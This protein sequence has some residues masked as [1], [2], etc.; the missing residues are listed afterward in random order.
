MV[1]M[2]GESSTDIY[3]F[4]CIKQIAG[5]K[6]LSSTESSAPALDDPEGWDGGGKGGRLKR[7]EIYV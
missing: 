4:L 3:I 1:E 2:N 6:V 7:E 5:G